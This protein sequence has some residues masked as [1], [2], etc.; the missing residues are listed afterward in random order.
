MPQRHDEQRHR[1]QPRDAENV[2]G[3]RFAPSRT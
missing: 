1:Q 3:Y 2:G